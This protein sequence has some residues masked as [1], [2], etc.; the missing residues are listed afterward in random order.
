MAEQ[1]KQ[2]YEQG[3]R[4]YVQNNAVKDVL[5]VITE[6][7]LTEKPADPKSWITDYLVAE[8]AKESGGASP[9]K[10]NALL[11]ELKEQQLENDRLKGVK[12][13]LF[14]HNIIMLTDSYKVTHF[15]QYPPNTET[16]YS[17]FESRGGKYPEIVFFGL[18]YF[19]KRY[20]VGKVVTQEKI[21][22]A[23][24]MVTAHLGDPSSFNREGWEYILQ[25][26][27]GVLPVVIKAVPEGM[28]VPV[29]NAMM[30]VENTDPKCYWLVNYLETLLV[31]VWYPMTVC[32]Q[33]R[34]QKTVIKEYLEKT[35]CSLDGLA[36]KLHDFGFR[37]VSSVESAA[38]G[39]AAHLVNFM[40]TDTMVG[41]VC[42]RMYYNEPMA[43]VSIPAAEHST[44]TSWGKEQE[45]DAFKNMLTSF[46]KGLVAVV[47]DSYD[48]YKA[49]TNLWGEQL[50]ELIE[51]RD[52]T[53]VVR[54]DSGDPPVIVVEVL[55]CLG[56]AFGTTET[57][58]GFKLLPKY[59]R[60]IQGDGISA[61]SLPGILDAMVA[62]NWAA[63]NIS[64]GSGGAL[65]QKVNRDTQKCAFKCSE[66]TVNGE[67]RDVY[68]DPITDPGKK[69]KKGRLT[70]EKN[71]DGEIVT[72][73]EGKGDP[74]KD[75]LVKVFENGKLLKD[76][77]F[78]EIKER[79]AV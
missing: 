11:K 64:F 55:E 56:K 69:S 75:L 22:Q 44:I 65:L 32:T 26:H 73:T 5:Q 76:Y 58:K 27:D 51:N 72:I 10:V 8:T 23:A 79:A 21:E 36:F 74:A 45:V 30:T 63:D 53:L 78:A 16:V 59:I 46:P 13:D 62:A 31:Q 71:E 47:S 6:K 67:V 7:L 60:V 41:Y 9:E 77:S 37:G 33:S 40:G 17:Y 43:G 2:E 68:K 61:D 12:D 38:I 57:S 39:G 49:C 29:K 20:L 15:K 66:A 48:I 35:G 19:I 52:G 50:K 1:Q 42:A 14:S 34:F 70:L 25:E 4:D 24:E 28:I 3:L 18:Q 54:P